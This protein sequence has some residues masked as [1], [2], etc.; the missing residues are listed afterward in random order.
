[1]TGKFLQE[2]LTAA[3]MT[4]NDLAAAL[5]ARGASVSRSRV[6]QWLDGDTISAYWAAR[7]EQVMADID[8]A[9]SERVARRMR[10]E[11]AVA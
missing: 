2:W 7:I 11:E 5:T 1:M 6:Y 9:D 3:R 10:R 8:A 4:A